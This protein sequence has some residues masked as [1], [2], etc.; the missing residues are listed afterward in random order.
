[1]NL[2]STSC[3][4]DHIVFPFLVFLYNAMATNALLRA[5]FVN[6]DQNFRFGLK[7][8]ITIFCHTQSEAQA[9]HSDTDSDNQSQKVNEWLTRLIILLLANQNMN[10]NEDDEI[11]VNDDTRQ[12]LFNSFIE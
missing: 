12:S 6:M 2:I 1:M 5:S 9:E 11:D 7:T 10:L 3:E 4:D 8:L